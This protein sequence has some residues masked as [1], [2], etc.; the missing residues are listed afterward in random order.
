MLRVLERPVLPGPSEIVFEFQVGIS[1][2]DERTVVG[3]L[4]RCGVRIDGKPA[5]V[6]TRETPVAEAFL[7]ALELA[8]RHGAAAV[9]VNDPQGLFPQWRRPPRPA[10]GGA[11]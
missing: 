11:R 6:Q 5:W 4:A 10:A 8:E 7:Q 2:V 3:H 1:T 9:W